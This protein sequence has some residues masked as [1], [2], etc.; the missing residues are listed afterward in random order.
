M[1]IV[2]EHEAALIQA[3]WHWGG[4]LAAVAELR[5]VFPIFQGNERAAD[6]VRMIA[7]WRSAGWRTGPDHP[8]PPSSS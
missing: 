5:R 2:S 1:F 6:A 4:E 3:A 7:G 8:D